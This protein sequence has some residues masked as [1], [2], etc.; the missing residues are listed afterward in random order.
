LEQAGIA[1][2]VVYSIFQEQIEYEAAEHDR[3][4]EFGCESYAEALSYFPAQPDFPRG[5][6]KY[7]EH[8]AA[9][10]DAL[11]I[12]V[13]ASLNGTTSGGWIEYAK[14]IERAGADA[15]ELNVYYIAANPEVSSEEI[16]RR[17]LD[18][19]AAVVGAVDIPVAM[20]LNPFVS[21]LANFAKR[22]D[23]AGASGLVLFNRFYQP[24]INLK[25]LAV[26]PTLESSVAHEMRLPLRWIA[27]LDPI[28]KCSLAG[29]TGVYSYSDVLKLMMAGADVAMLCAA[30]L[31]D[32][33]S[34]V[35]SILEGMEAWMKEHG[36]ESVR[37][38]QGMMNQASCSNPAAFERANYMQALS[39]YKTQI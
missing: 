8:I 32:G 37:Q 12:P 27:V 7:V 5:P 15:I 3:Q 11:D 2:I 36:H 14:G 34:V 9:L 39:S 20:K 21:A 6:E 38:V 28:V 17:Y 1:A 30:I 18:V 23:E 31:R 25:D 29:S 10:K 13:I 26:T 33:P 4:M 16:E 22:L 19:L 24:D 35:G